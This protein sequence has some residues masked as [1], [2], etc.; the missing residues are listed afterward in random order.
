MSRARAAALGAALMI[1]SFAVGPAAGQGIE[2]HGA[3]NWFGMGEVNDS[4]ASING[5]LG[6]SLPA[7]DVGDSWGLAL[8][9]WPSPDVLLRIGGEWLHAESEDP[10]VA[11]EVNAIAATLGVTWFT[12]ADGPVRLGVSLALG[13]YFAMGGIRGSDADLDASGVGFGLSPGAE[14]KLQLSET[15]SVT[16]S[17]GYRWAVIPDLDFGG[18]GT[19]L[20]ANYSGGFLRLALALESANR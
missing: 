18:N 19:D 17:G 7:I 4:L 1:V 9:F 8:R 14:A 6:T 16:G 3:V 15:F 5:A 11:V 12:T 13:P 10:D 20:D 2:V